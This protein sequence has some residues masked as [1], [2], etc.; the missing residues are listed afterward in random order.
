MNA[1]HQSWKSRQ[2]AAPKNQFVVERCIFCDCGRQYTRY[3]NG[4][5]FAEIC[6]LCNGKGEIVIERAQ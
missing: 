3:A 2:V 5:E 4:T 1:I 6:R